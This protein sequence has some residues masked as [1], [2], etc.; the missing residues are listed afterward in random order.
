MNLPVPDNLV[1]AALG[2]VG[3]GIFALLG[4]AATT[5]LSHRLGRDERIYRRIFESALKQWEAQFR[6][7]ELDPKPTHVI[8]PLR[9]W[10]LC[11]CAIQS[12]MSRGPWI[13]FWI[14]KWMNRRM[15]TRIIEALKEADKFNDDI[16]K[17]EI[18]IVKARGD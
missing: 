4:G 3:G 8:K 15:R 16:Y 13:P 9:Y 6:L 12:V 18:S 11:E 10:V 5:W 17:H 7:M 2:G 14:V 1:Y